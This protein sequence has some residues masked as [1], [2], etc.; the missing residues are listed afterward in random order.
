M[1]TGR[2]AVAYEHEAQ[3][4]IQGRFKY[5]AIFLAMLTFIMYLSGDPYEEDGLQ[6]NTRSTP[7]K[8]KPD[9]IALPSQNFNQNNALRVSYSESSADSTDDDDDEKYDE[10]SADSIDDYD[11]EKYYDDG[12]IM[13]PNNLLGDLEID[14]LE[15]MEALFDEAENEVDNEVL[16]TVELEEIEL[17]DILQSKGISVTEDEVQDI[18]IEAYIK[19]S[20]KLLSTLREE[21]D[22]VVDEDIEEIEDEEE[23]GYE[24]KEEEVEEMEDEEIEKVKDIVEDTEARIEQVVVEIVKELVK[25]KY[26]VEVDIGNESSSNASGYDGNNS[27]DD[28]GNNGDEDADDNYSESGDEN[29]DGNEYND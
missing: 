5:A 6:S 11:D 21:I 27:G 23:S 2:V 26:N 17:Q 25:A 7:K 29:A 3:N 13:V 18:M 4:R 24:V 9:H 12:G 10:S 8:Q 15:D 19:A 16:I 14:L 20:E 1:S 22:L 28:G